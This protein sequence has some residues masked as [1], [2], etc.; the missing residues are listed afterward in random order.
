MNEHEEEGFLG[1]SRELNRFKC[2][3][4]YDGTHY[5]GFQIQ[6]NALSVQEKLEQALKRMHNEPV[7]VVGSGRTDAGVHAR[8]QVFHF[9]SPLEIRMDKWTLALNSYL[10]KDIRIQSTEPIHADFHARHDVTR[11]QYRYH[12]YRS[13]LENPN[14]RLYWAH[15]PYGLDMDAI[16][17]AAKVLEGEHDFTAFSS[18]KSD[19]NH[20]VR[21][22]KRL[23]IEERKVEDGEEIVLI[24]EGNGFLY[25]M[26]RIIAG[27]LID[28]GR[29]RSSIEQV[30]QALKLKER[31]LA[32]KTAP[33]HGLNLWW[34]AYD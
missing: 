4:S 7:A 24:C 11:K 29:G 32:G 12:I 9:D 31:R 22:I 1:S 23:D 5:H 8:G 33:A 2:T 20:R 10:P 18:A 30:Q 25:N 15:V 14:R 16:R 13:R 28:V 17:A 3:V 34:V 26:V 19:A 6:T 27:T 21:T